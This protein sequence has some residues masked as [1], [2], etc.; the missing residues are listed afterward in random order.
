MREPKATDGKPL[1]P[2][3]SIEYR[4]ASQHPAVSAAAC[5]ATELV[6]SSACFPLLPVE[7]TISLR[8]LNQPEA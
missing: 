6:R 5:A 4:T 1:S 2:T 7:Q 8:R 3:H